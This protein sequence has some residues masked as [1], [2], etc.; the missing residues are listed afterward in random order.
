MAKAQWPPHALRNQQ[1]H[2]RDTRSCMTFSVA[3]EQKR[4]CMRQKTTFAFGDPAF[5][6]PSRR[7]VDTRR[8][9]PPE[10]WNMMPSDRLITRSQGSLNRKTKRPIT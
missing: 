6:L 7:I 2:P 1:S 8:T 4:L 9:P 5:L 3:A 10:D